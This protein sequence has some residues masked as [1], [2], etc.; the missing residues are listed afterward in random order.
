MKSEKQTSS[1]K[2]L[3]E[4]F[5]GRYHNFSHTCCLISIT[6]WLKETKR[7]SCS[8]AFGSVR[9]TWCA[10]LWREMICPMSFFSWAD[11]MWIHCSVTNKVSTDH[12]LLLTLTQSMISVSW[13]LVS[14]GWRRRIGGKSWTS[15][16]ASLPV[17]PSCLWS[18]E[19]DGARQTDDRAGGR[20]QDQHLL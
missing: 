19:E 18:H 4:S 3:Q 16:S 1:R 5:W 6:L 17:C 12:E 7:Y 8:D 10:T 2:T 14:C 20:Q 9:L 15:G 13:N 11:E